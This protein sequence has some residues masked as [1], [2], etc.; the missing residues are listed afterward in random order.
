MLKIPFLFFIGFF[1]HLLSSSTVQGRKE[2]QPVCRIADL[3]QDLSPSEKYNNNSGSNRMVNITKLS[4]P[5]VLSY[6]V[7][8]DGLKCAE[9]YNVE[10]GAK[11]ATLYH[12]FSV[13]KSWT[14]LLIGILVSMGYLSLQETLS[15]IWPDIH[16]ASYIKNITVEELLTMTSGC[17][18]REGYEL[19][20]ARM[21]ERTFGGG[22]LT[23]SLNYPDCS[24]P[25]SKKEFN[26]VEDNTLSY[27]IYQRSGMMPQDF[28]SKHLMP[29]LGMLNETWSWEVNLDGI[30]YAN[31]GFST[32]T[33]NLA[34]FG[35][36]YLQNGFASVSKQVVPQSWVEQSTTSHVKILPNHPIRMYMT[37]NV[38]QSVDY[39]YR[40]WIIGTDMKTRYC[41]N[42][43]F[44]HYICVWPKMGRVMAVNVAQTKTLLDWL[45]WDFVE[46]VG[47]L[48]FH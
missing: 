41:A 28:A 35:Q 18:G 3:S 36:L 33:V 7:L 22:N 24:N 10:Q 20:S 30:A 27:I 48:Q 45:G 34:K 11:K 13:T 38:D 46:M 16:N 29:F 25:S 1:H 17:K 47:D 43:A 40:F 9:Y 44:G 4:Y 32:T 37:D 15:D 2:F 6:V 39:G 23:N 5:Q 31:A 12:V 14:S 26:Y 42:G 8:E 19:F 21:K